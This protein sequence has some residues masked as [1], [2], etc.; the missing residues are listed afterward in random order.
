MVQGIGGMGGAGL[1]LL[2]AILLLA[3]INRSFGIETKEPGEEAARLG[4]QDETKQRPRDNEDGQE[5]SPNAGKGGR[6]V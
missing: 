3:A 1:P 4:D 5:I 6:S 2:L